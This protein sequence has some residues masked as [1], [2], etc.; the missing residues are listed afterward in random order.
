MKR[1]INHRFLPLLPVGV[2]TATLLLISCDLFSDENKAVIDP[3]PYFEVDA[4]PAWSPSGR[5]IAYRHDPRINEDS[6]GVTGLYLL[7]LETDST[8]L[9]I[10]GPAHSPTWRPNGERIAFS[11]GDIYTI[12][13][14]GSDLRHIVSLENAFFPR[15]SPDGQALA[16]YS[17]SGEVGGT[18]FFHFGDSTLTHFGSGENPDWSPSGERIVYVNDRKLWTADTSRT[19]STRLTEYNPGEDRYPNWG[20]SGEQIAWLRR[21]DSGEDS[22]CKVN[23][24]RPSGTGRRSLTECTMVPSLTWGPDGRRLIFPKRAPESRSTA[25]WMIRRDGSGLRQLT[26][27][28]NNP[29]N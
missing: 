9:L 20:P 10:E 7:D 21:E 19:D 12:A 29:L 24:V 15:Y 2:F 27:P 23:L 28:T 5:Y 8:R 25:L 14:D 3:V 17:T 22:S 26:D 4:T 1:P 6:T 13:P 11:T 16:F 18:W